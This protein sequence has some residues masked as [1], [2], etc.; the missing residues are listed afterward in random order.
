MCRSIQRSCGK[1]SGYHIYFD[2]N[3]ALLMRIGI[4]FN[5]S[6]EKGS[7]RHLQHII[8]GWSSINDA[9]ARRVTL[10]SHGCVAEIFI[11]YKGGGECDVTP[12]DRRPV[13][14]TRHGLGIKRKRRSR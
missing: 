6:L 13:P 10:G 7:A 11:K 2:A 3:D 14:R 9:H 4:T 5:V 1:V 12:W 8:Q